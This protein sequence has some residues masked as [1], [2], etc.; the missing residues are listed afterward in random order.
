MGSRGRRPASKAGCQSIGA[1]S[2]GA[3]EGLGEDETNKP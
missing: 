3:H 2:R 1:E